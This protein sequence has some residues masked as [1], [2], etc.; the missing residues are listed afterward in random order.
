MK[1]TSYRLRTQHLTDC[2]QVFMDIVYGKDPL[3]RVVIGMY[4]DATPKTCANFVAL[5]AQLST[6]FRRWAP[7]HSLASS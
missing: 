2:W 5:G 4:G 6:P 1:L 7:D 3:G